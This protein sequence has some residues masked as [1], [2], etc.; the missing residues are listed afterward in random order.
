MDEGSKSPFSKRIYAIPFGRF[1]AGGEAEAPAH[2]V[3][4][5]REGQRAYFIDILLRAGRRGAFLVTGHRG[6]GKTSFVRYCLTE[7]SRE[8]YERFLRSNVGKAFFWDR[9]LVFSL[10]FVVLLLA[11]L[12]S[13]LMEILI[14]GHP[15]GVNPKNL[16]RWLL[17]APLAVV[18]LYPLLFAREVLSEITET[19]VSHFRSTR[20]RPGPVFAGLAVPVLAFALWWVPPLGAPALSMSRLFGAICALYLWV[21]CSS[22]RQWD[23]RSGEPNRWFRRWSRAWMM[24]T[25]VLAVVLAAAYLFRRTLLFQTAEPLEEIRCNFGLGLVFLGTG[26]F[27]QGV[28]RNLMRKRLPEGGTREAAGAGARRYRWIGFGIAALGFVLLTIEAPGASR[29]ACLWTAL[30]SIGVASLVLYLLHARHSRDQRAEPTSFRFQPRPLLALA[31][32]ALFCLVI[33]LQLIHPVVAAWPYTLDGQWFTDVKQEKLPIAD[34]LRTPGALASLRGLRYAG[35]QNV[36][37]EPADEHLWVLG[38]FLLLVLLYYLDYEWIVRPL[39]GERED[40]TIGLWRRGPDDEKANEE[41][42]GEREGARQ[43]RIA[44][45]LAELTLPWL[46]YRAWLPVLTISVNLGFEKLDHRRVVQAMLTGLRSKY[47]RAFLAWNSGIAN[48]GRILGGLLLLMLVALVGERWFSMPPVERPPLA[49]NRS[50]ASAGAEG[51]PMRRAALALVA[52]GRPG[53]PE[54]IQPDYADICHAFQGRQVGGNSFVNLVCKLPWGSRI[55]HILYY[56]FISSDIAGGSPDSPR[57]LSFLLPPGEQWPP[58][59]TGLPALFPEGVHFR[60]Y[61]LL[62][63]LT[64]FFTGRWLFQKLP[65]L[66]YH[67][68]LEKIDEVLESLTSSTSTTSR[69]GRWQPMQW[70]EGF[71]LNERVR[72]LQQEPFDPR[73]IEF[74]FLQILDEMREAAVRL[75][76]ARNQLVSLPVPEVTFVFDE[77][78]KLG[79]R[80]DP[81]SDRAE[82]PAGQPSESLNAERRRSLELHRLFADMKNLLSSAP[83]RFIFVGGRNLHDEWLA[84]QASRQPLLTNIFNAEVYLPSLLTDFNRRVSD[85]N[86]KVKVESYVRHQH[87]RAEELYAQHYRKLSLPSFALAAENLEEESFVPTGASRLGVLPLP[88]IADSGKKIEGGDEVVAELV[89]FLAYRSL[90][91]PKRLKELLSLF[92]RPVGRVVQSAAARDRFDCQHVLAL[93]ETERFRVQLVARIY[94]SVERILQGG[95]ARRDDKMTVSLVF[96][97]DF[98]FKFHARAFSWSSLER[99]D[100]LVHIHRAPDLREVL[101]DLVERWSERA[102]QRIRN[103][104]YDFRFQSQFA[105]EIQHISRQSPEEMAAF[106]FTLDESQG[107]KSI[108]L[109]SLDRLQKER[110]KELRDVV[111]GLGELHEFDQEYETARFYYRWA[112]SLLDMELREVVGGSNFLEENSPV[113]EVMSGRQPGP[114]YARLYL[115]WGIARLRLM[116]QVGMTFELSRNLER[117]EVEYRDSHIFARSL[118]LAMLNEGG[119]D[120][121]RAQ[122]FNHLNLLFQPAFAEVWVAEKL[123]GGVDTSIDRAEKE[124][125]ELRKLLPFVRDPFV[126]TPQAPSGIRHSNFGLIMAELSNKLGDLYFFKG[127]Q[128]VPEE[129]IQQAVEERRR[130]KDGSD[131]L[132]RGPE[133]Y[134]LRAHYQY[135]VA[136]HELRRFTTYRLRSSAPKLNIWPEATRWPTIAPGGWPDIVCRAA[137]GFFNDIA[138][139]MLGRISVYGLLADP[140]LQTTG[141]AANKPA[142]EPSEKEIDQCR[143]ELIQGVTEWMESA[144]EERTTAATGRPPS[145]PIRIPLTGGEIQADTIEGWLGTWRGLEDLGSPDE[146]LLEFGETAGHDDL[147]RLAVALQ[148]MLV[149][150]KYLERGGYVEEAAMELLKIC[151]TVTHYLWWGAGVRRVIAWNLHGTGSG[152]PEVPLLKAV[153]STRA[154]STR[155]HSYWAYLIKVAV[156]ALRSADRLFRRSRR[157]EQTAGYLLGDQIPPAAATLACSLGLVARHWDRSGM[158]REPLQ[159]L[160]R[161]WMGESFHPGEPREFRKKLRRSLVEIFQRHSY[162]INNRLRALKTWIDDAVLGATDAGRKS[163]PLFRTRVL[164]ATEELIL[165]NTDFQAPLHFTPLHSGTT[166]ALVYLCFFGLRGQALCEETMKEGDKTK[167]EQTKEK[168]RRTAQVDLVRSEEMSTMRR[169]FYES[170]SRLF[171][172][173]DDFNDRQVHFNHAVQMAGSEYVSLLRYLVSWRDYHLQNQP[174]RG[175]SEEAAGRGEA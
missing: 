151:E 8:V 61:H 84:D 109:A 92:I 80:S 113:T 37:H 42:E 86:L 168:I 99:V 98:L 101:E 60:V 105:R 14:P 142:Q 133:G 94:A 114:E 126:G 75:P 104:M 131:E 148:L 144:E 7:Y 26:S 115:A 29:Q 76:G 146:M 49:Q 135:A 54:P 125:R 95:F 31:V 81:V 44:R 69:K 103:G 68:A 145:H 46:L 66:P 171:Y 134:L 43:R 16:L 130:A 163:K 129:A 139:A 169:S 162:P 6:V 17:I 77:L 121:E 93:D 141:K 57:L 156:H 79:S 137:G 39:R 73:T 10:I 164:N 150:T 71:F 87:V 15:G 154:E 153:A 122:I 33:A 127:R 63:V 112:I 107:L 5:G 90:G 40:E 65:I 116:L 155:G 24:L 166:C 9:I 167:I 25:L 175:G 23:D 58:A 51:I 62:L 18:C 172:L 47:H 157:V 32:K 158:V 1:Q 83:A 2:Q 106:N 41:K 117:A 108:Y 55:F 123:E 124:L 120:E 173:Y 74:L 72:Q 165:L 96:L 152:V 143:R 78:D 38:A 89:S 118:L 20:G 140:R 160:L 22:F 138:E 34:Q 11:L 4:V 59:H 159:A 97:S 149:G 128:V 3:L 21:Q 102:L 27:L 161:S 136:L 100:E 70:V 170:I 36:F 132:R 110:S 85:V 53:P 147:A 82:S 56:N 50:G 91:N 28:H 12:A 35:G 45:K 119:Q 19:L 30:F 48:L 13:E 111:A 67:T 174:P 88:R 52:Y 64:F